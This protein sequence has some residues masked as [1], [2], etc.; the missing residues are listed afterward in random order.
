MVN[1]LYDRARITQNH[2]KFAADG[3]IAASSEVRSLAA[4][5]LEDA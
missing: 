5:A 1:Y 2:E 3:T 4:T